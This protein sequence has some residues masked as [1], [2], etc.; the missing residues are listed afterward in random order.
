IDWLPADNGEG[1]GKKDLMG[2]ESDGNVL[3]ADRVAA[4]HSHVKMLTAT[5]FFAFRKGLILNLF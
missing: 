3:E 5:D 2:K 4:L 1:T